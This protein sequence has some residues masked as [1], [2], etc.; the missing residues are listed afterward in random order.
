MTPLATHDK[1]GAGD[2]KSG[3][4]PRNA[5]I[6]RPIRRTVDLDEVKQVEKPSFVKT[7][8]NF[9]ADAGTGNLLPLKNPL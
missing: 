8:A 2:H 7:L 9:L 4:L 1:T 6:E 5:L 3:G